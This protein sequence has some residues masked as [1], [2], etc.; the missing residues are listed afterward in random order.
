[1]TE[2]E[3]I[4][5]VALHQHVPMHARWFSSAH[6][7][8]ASMPVDEAVRILA[9]AYPEEVIPEIASFC[10]R[11]PASMEMPLSGLMLVLASRLPAGA[12]PRVDEEVRR[13]LM[14][15]AGQT[16]LPFAD[17]GLIVLAACH[18][19]GWIREKAVRLVRILPEEIAVRLLL[20]RIN[21]WA[22]PVRN[23]AELLL[24]PILAKLSPDQKMALVPL[25][26]RLRHCG[27]H[28]NSKTVEAWRISLI[29]PFD[30]KEWLG[31][32]LRSEGR[33]RRVYLELLKQT[34]TIPG[35]AVRQALLKSNDRMALLWYLKEILPRLEDNDRHEATQMISRS[36]AVP[37]RREWLGQL[38]EIDRAKAVP[39]LM[40]TL[41]DRSRSL[42]H[43]AR[44]HLAR[45][46]PLLDLAAHYRSALHSPG[47]EAVALRGLT[48]VAPADGYQ[49]A[50]QR[51]SSPASMVRKAAV[52]SLPPDR[53]GEH[54][55]RLLE[56]ASESEPGPSKSAR[57]RLVEIAPELGDHLLTNPQAISASPDDLQLQFIRLAPFFR[58]WQGLEYLL[59]RL[60]HHGARHKKLVAL[61]VWQSR[62]RL[63]FIPLKEEGRLRLL[64]LLDKL[65]L[66]ERV[67]GELRFIL[68]RGE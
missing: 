19:S 47:L 14:S 65:D 31:S 63:S 5:F 25:V 3:H 32:W 45:L 2:L 55:D 9:S 6:L 26:D 53:L 27:R 62:E 58:K 8:E 39:L 23:R 30:E 61:R 12:W 34:G 46:T 22:R 68:E 20:V 48:E 16:D 59:L 52:E 18:P 50:V 13:R 66:P 36:R 11:R 10:W 44:F 24:S 42:R 38:V 56:I 54:L 21:D 64:K 33:D 51:L 67:G 41:T 4:A 43:F 49:E 57:R 17:P 28:G 29:T 60:L 37:V 15:F 40:E 1:V 35:P 7:D